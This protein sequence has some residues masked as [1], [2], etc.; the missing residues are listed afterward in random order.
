[1]YLTK[2]KALNL[3]KFAKAHGVDAWEAYTKHGKRIVFVHG[4]DLGLHSRNGVYG[5]VMTLRKLRFYLGY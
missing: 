2:T 4:R 5:K 1:M 3:I